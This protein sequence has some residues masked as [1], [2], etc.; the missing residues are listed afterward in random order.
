MGSQTTT[1][2][3]TADKTTL[4]I[5]ARRRAAAE[6]LPGTYTPYSGE[7]VAG[8][9]PQQQLA[10]QQVQNSAMQAQPGIAQAAGMIQPFT[11]TNVQGQG[12]A[13]ANAGLPGG[14]QAADVNAE[15]V[16]ADAFPDANLS[17][18]L[19]PH[20]DNVVEKTNADIERTRRIQIAQGQASATAAGAYSG[21]R[22]GVADSL[23]NEAALR[24]TAL[25]DAQ[26]RSAGYSEAQ[27]AISRDQD[28]ALS[29]GVANQ[30]AALQAGIA[31]QGAGIQS[32]NIAKDIGMFNAGSVNEASR[33]TAGAQ[34]TAALANQGAQATAAGINLQGAGLL[35]DLS[36][37]GQTAALQGASANAA[38]GATQQETEQARKTAAFEEWKVKQQFPYQYQQ[39]LQ[40][41]N[42]TPGQRTVSTT[43]SGLPGQIL[44]AAATVG[45][46]ALT[47]GTSL[48]AQAAAKA[49]KGGVA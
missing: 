15:R 36:V 40:G 16:S 49:A 19:N 46:A 10:H 32:A 34:N 45:A 8:L 18:Y 43:P 6:K 20:I 47:G 31:N 4:A 29:A 41:F 14:F 27:I 38:A 2:T 26:L 17:A 44:G 37:A 7:Q 9:T 1:S 24:T 12:Y 23:T 33:F 13:A 3:T 28:R 39:F 35:G 48:A 42:G 21:S 25:S 30:N 5:E 22:H 11:A